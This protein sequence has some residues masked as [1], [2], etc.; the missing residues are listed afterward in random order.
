MYSALVEKLGVLP[1]ETLVCKIRL[2]SVR[3]VNGWAAK[4][5]GMPCTGLCWARVHGEEHRVRAG[6]GARERAAAGA[7]GMGPSTARGK[8]PAIGL[9]QQV[10]HSLTGEPLPCRPTCPRSLRPSKRSW[11]PTRLFGAGKPP[12]WRIAGCKVAHGR[13]CWYFSMRR[14]NSRAHAHGHCALRRCGGSAGR[15]SQAQDRV[16]PAAALSEVGGGRRRKRLGD[17]GTLRGS[18][19]HRAGGKGKMAATALLNACRKAWMRS[20][21]SAEATG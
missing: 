8:P 6:S 15:C 21:D 12:C 3:C 19:H 18:G 2:G 4:A 20:S 13:S 7:A 9:W 10:G 17:R 11:K 1:P 5:P 16:G 14:G